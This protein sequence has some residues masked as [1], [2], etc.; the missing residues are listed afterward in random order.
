MTRWMRF[1]TMPALVFIGGFLISV[2]SARAQEEEFPGVTLGLLYETAYQPALALK[3]FAGRLGGEGPVAQVEAIIGRD[4]RYTDRL[5]VMDS[6]PE[7]LVGGDIDYGL[8]DKL[9]AVWLLSG[10][11]EGAGEGYVLSVELHDVVYGEV[12]NRGRFRIPD[13]ESPDFRLATHIVSD[14]V[15]RWLFDEPGMAASRIAFSRRSD[16]GQTQEL[17]MIDSDGENFRRVTRYGSITLSPTWSPDGKRIAYTSYKSDFPRIYELNLETGEERLLEPVR[18]GDY[19]TPTYNP[20]GREIAFTITGGAQSG[21]FTYD[22]ERDCCL[23]HLSGGRWNDLSPTYS[24]DGRWLALN[25][26][27]LG[28]A[29]PQIYVM[30]AGG[31]EADLISPY[32]HGNEGY[33]TSPDWSPVGDFVAFHGRIGRFGRYQILV[34]DVSDRGRRLRQLTSEGNNEDPS[35]APDGRHLVFVG[36]RDWGTGLMVVDTAT[37]NIRLL[38]RGL[39]IRIP[40][41]GPSLAVDGPD[42]LRGGGF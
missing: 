17:Y 36:R 27:R 11:L 42:T 32:L 19:I 25:S 18:E 13:A 34:A 12:R 21:L 37:G 2:G 15:V 1:W 26:N 41:W 6:L 3:P 20:N 40:E 30:P 10:R 38:L 31:G 24:P 14:A 16:D 23:T 22:L 35:W 28:T 29:T 9:G 4:L 7:A 5:Q 39:D 8:W 33:Y